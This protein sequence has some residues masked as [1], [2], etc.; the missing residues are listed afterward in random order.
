MNLWSEGGFNQVASTLAERLAPK[1]REGQKP[2][3]R[4]DERLGRKPRG[5]ALA[6]H[7]RLS[8]TCSRQN[9]NDK[10]CHD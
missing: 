5:W 4:D 2:E 1:N 3:A 10:K 8:H 7:A 6:A 9:G